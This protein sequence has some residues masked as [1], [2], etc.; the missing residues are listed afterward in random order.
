MGTRII[1]IL[2]SLMIVIGCGVDPNEEFSARWIKSIETLPRVKG[3]QQAG[4]FNMNDTF[5]AQFCDSYGNQR[6]MRYDN[7]THKW[8]GVKYVT[9]GCRSAEYSESP[10]EG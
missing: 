9:W 7:E 1:F 3:F 5:I 6:W 8:S 4:I 2:I 10:S